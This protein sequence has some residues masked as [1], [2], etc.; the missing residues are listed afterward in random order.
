MSLLPVLR[1]G[2][3]THRMGAGH[4]CK[5]RRSEG[6]RGLDRVIHVRKESGARV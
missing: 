1:C 4:L 2:C 3:D 6:M 5:D